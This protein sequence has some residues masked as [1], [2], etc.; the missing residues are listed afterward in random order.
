MHWLLAICA[1]AFAADE[2]PPPSETVHLFNGQD[3]S[4]F[5]TFLRE[6][7][8]DN[9]PLGVFSVQDGL[10]RISG[11]EWGCLTTHEEFEDFRLVVEF[12]WGERTWGDRVDRARDSGILLHSV[13]EDGAYGDIWMRSIECQM[14]EGGTGDFIVVGDDTDAFSLTAPVAPEMQDKSHVFQLD[15]MPA[16]IHGGRI[17]WFGRDPDWRDVKGFRGSRDVE[18]PVGE[19]NTYEIVADGP[20]VTVRLNGVLV[21]KAFDVKPRRGRIQIQSEAA[22]LFV[23]RFDLT[24]LD[25]GRPRDILLVVNKH[26]DTVSY[27]DPATLEPVAKVK[28]GHDP[29]EMVITPGRRFAYISNY[30]APGNTISV[31]DLVKREHVQQIPTDPYV[32]IHS[33]AL[34]PDGRFAYFTAGQTGYVVEVDTQENRVTRG[35]P[36]H[37]KIS[38]MVIVSPD[39][40]RLYTAN[41]GTQNV[42]AIDRESGDLIKQIACDRGCEGLQ[43]T[44]DAR[45]LWAANQDAGNITVI[46]TE[47]LEAVETIPCA[48]MPLR[49]RFTKDGTRA[50]VSN[51]VEKGELVVLDVKGRREIKRIPVG[52]QPIGIELS[53]DEK[54]AFV[55]SMTSDE[56]HVVDLDALEVAGRFVTGKGPDAMAWWTPPE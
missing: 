9:D 30:A 2:T 10:L 40:K 22:E 5:Y 15:G 23:R 50:L 18:K 55:T 39:G 21:N 13:G 6:R 54:R 53:P 12:K 3:L 4:N 29:H 46:D 14:I 24:P 1:A 8:R 28:T 48:G 11:E 34:A 43:F 16:T 49:I 7:G 51:W 52:N 25:P 32:R 47:S 20:T 56:V 35:I 42:S 17:N 37:G 36:T 26:E 44:S 27:V 33:A 45:H 41:I 19:W 38:H 31:M